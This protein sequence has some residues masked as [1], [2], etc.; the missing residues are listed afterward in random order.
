MGQVIHVSVKRY[1]LKVFHDGAVVAVLNSHLSDHTLLCSI[2]AV[3]KFWN[4]H[5]Q[6]AAQMPEVL[7]ILSIIT[8]VLF[9][10]ILSDLHLLNEDHC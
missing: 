4:V 3:G 6:R 7:C 9:D 8:K 1:T 5:L 2:R 10:L